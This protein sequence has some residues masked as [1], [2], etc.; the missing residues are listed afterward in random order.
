MLIIVWYVNDLLKLFFPRTSGMH[1][2]IKA[3]FVSSEGY[4][5]NNGVLQ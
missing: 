3:Q 4:I 5:R 2:I 1:S